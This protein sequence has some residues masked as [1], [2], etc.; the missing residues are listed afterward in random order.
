MV[1]IALQMRSVDERR[2]HS[3]KNGHLE[4]LNTYA[5]KSKRLGNGELPNGY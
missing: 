2:V 4:C 5:K 3:A 1:N